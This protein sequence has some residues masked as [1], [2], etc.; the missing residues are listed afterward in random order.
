METNLIKRQKL[1]SLE[2]LEDHPKDMDTVE[3]PGVVLHLVDIILD[4]IQL[5]GKGEGVSS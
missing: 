1:E 4:R 3:E 5:C 2:N